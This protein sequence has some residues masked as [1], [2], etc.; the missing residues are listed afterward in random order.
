VALVAAQVRA[1][2]VTAPSKAVA[3]VVV[4]LVKAVVT[5]VQVLLYW[6]FQMQTI[7]EVLQVLQ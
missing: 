6:Y 7:Q 2:D 1:E 3:V 4:L 5:A